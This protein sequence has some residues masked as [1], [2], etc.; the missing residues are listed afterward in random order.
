MLNKQSY[1]AKLC[2]QLVESKNRDHI[3]KIEPIGIYVDWTRLAQMKDVACIPQ[4][5]DHDLLNCRDAISFNTLKRFK[6]RNVTQ[7]L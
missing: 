4:Q 3:P 5:V 7:R 2:P 1:I 6:N